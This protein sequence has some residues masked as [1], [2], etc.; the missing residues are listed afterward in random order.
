MGA[1]LGQ[2]ATGNVFPGTHKAIEIILGRV[3]HKTAKKGKF[4]KILARGGQQLP[5]DMTC[6]PVL[7]SHQVM[8]RQKP[9]FSQRI[10]KTP[11]SKCYI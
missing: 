8:Q 5:L 6:L 10:C 2:R 4:A 1:F 7:V 9:P 3:F 11:L